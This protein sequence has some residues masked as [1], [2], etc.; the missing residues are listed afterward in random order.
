MSVLD[1]L[2]FSSHPLALS[3]T[4]LTLVLRACIQSPTAMK[5]KVTVVKVK[6]IT[7]FELKETFSNSTSE[8]LILL[9]VGMRVF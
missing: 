7:I 2:K 3:S 8:S 5:P 4:I 1:S 6:T 9:K